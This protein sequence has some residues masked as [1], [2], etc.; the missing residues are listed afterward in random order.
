MVPSCKKVVCSVDLLFDNRMTY[1]FL[2]VDNDFSC[3][4]N[5]RRIDNWGDFHIPPID[6]GGSISML[7][8]IS[9]IDEWSKSNE[10][11]KGYFHGGTLHPA[12]IAEKV[13]AYH[14]YEQPIWGDVKSNVEKYME[15]MYGTETEELDF[16]D[17]LL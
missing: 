11:I 8:E 15:N 7:G 2:P 13:L 14:F 1:W 5:V 17:E 9:Q 3:K 4:L 12:F 6:L 10:E 16:G